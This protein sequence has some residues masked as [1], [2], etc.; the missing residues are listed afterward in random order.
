MRVL[1]YTLF[2]IV[3]LFLPAWGDGDAFEQA[4]AQVGL[5]KHMARFN[6][7]DL[8]LYGG[9]E[10][11][12]PFFDSVHLDPWRVPFVVRTL[13]QDCLQNAGNIASLLSTASLRLS[14]GTR[15]TL[16]S[17]PTESLKRKADG[18]HQ[19][20]YQAVAAIYRAARQKVPEKAAWVGQ[21]AA[22][23]MQVQ[24]PVAYLL[25]AM[26]EA[27]RWRDLAFR[28]AFTQ[29][30]AQTFFEM[31]CQPPSES[32]KLQDIFHT[33]YWRLVRAVDLKALFAGAHDLMLVSE[34]VATELRK[35]SISDG[36][37]VD[38]PTPYGIVALHDRRADTYN[39]QKYLL[40]VD[41]GGNDT[42]LGAGG[43][44]S[45]DHP[46]AVVID[47]KGNDRYLQDASMASRGVADASDRKTR[48]VSPCIGGAV[49]GYAFM[50]DMDGN[51]LY[52]S[53]A[54]TQGGA[55][56]GVGA[57][58]DNAGDDR[59]ECYVNGQ[60]GADWGIG[61]LVDRTG[62]DSYH[63]F[64]MAQGY[65]AT[66]GYGLLLDVEGD[67][68]YTADDQTL[69]FPS[70]QTDKHNVSL[71]Q[72]A[73]YGRRADY[74]D[75]HSLAGGIG[76]LVDGAGNDRY[77]CG[78]FGQGVGYWYGLGILSDGGGDDVYEGVWYVQGASA[79]FAVGIL[80]DTSGDDHYVATMNMAQGAGHDFSLGWLIE[81]GG[82]DVYR[83]PNLSLGGGNANGIGIFWDACG[84]DRY[85]V[86]PSI[87]L[88]RSSIGARG[89]LR[90]RAL[91]LGLFCDTG[92]K[93][94][95]PEPL[96]F[97]HDNALWAQ[98]GASQPPMRLEYG[99]GIDCEQPVK[100]E[101]L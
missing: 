85:E 84:D 32:E 74:T 71:A 78:V 88:G 35:T 94:T 16:I 55:V 54:I 79:H 56:F 25:L 93:D 63:C 64:S 48:R 30:S 89:S 22:V 87:T 28:D 82:N 98:S 57:L 73:G 4:L 31:L 45:A 81:L 21:L 86:Q 23:P 75:G 96:S 69:D 40:I 37:R 99:A 66:K 65:G 72:G 17:D 90:E 39:R 18:F 7:L 60:G 76:V 41:T 42:Y 33:A 2:V 62:N 20:L 67:D 29:S 15:R 34:R 68:T 92:G 10:Y 44:A 52:R 6:P 24:K 101:D 80:E 8:Q 1:V 77:S 49:L 91:C 95:Y 46:I 47:L 36:F 100:P 26:V 61:L 14:E 43:T 12:L 50:L 13:R 83:A 53:L 58:I 9:G 70:P 11:R 38:I 59:Y 51:D 97:A 27:R 5:T 3:C 19:P